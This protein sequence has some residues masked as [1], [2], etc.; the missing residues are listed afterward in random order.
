MSLEHERGARQNVE[1]HVVNLSKFTSG[2]PAKKGRGKTAVPPSIG[3]KTINPA[4]PNNVEK[5]EGC[6]KQLTM[7]GEKRWKDVERGFIRDP[8][9]TGHIV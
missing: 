5:T 8:M 7:T 3:R 9:K 1:K 6:S 4:Q 2:P